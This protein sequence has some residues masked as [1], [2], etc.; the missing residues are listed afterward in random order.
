MNEPPSAVV[1][2]ILCIKWAAAEK[3]R[4]LV[5]LP[6][7]DT[8]PMAKWDGYGTL[9]EDGVGVLSLLGCRSVKDV[10]T[11]SSPF[12]LAC[13]QRVGKGRLA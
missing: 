6:H 11:K 4:G 1:C 3:S 2:Q 7:P 12:S 10:V 5:R 9:G 13:Q 8:L